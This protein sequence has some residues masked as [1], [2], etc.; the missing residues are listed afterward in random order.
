MY[1]VPPC[2]ALC[3]T[4]RSI[5]GRAGAANFAPGSDNDS[6]SAARVFIYFTGALNSDRFHDPASVH[7]VRNS[8]RRSLRDLPDLACVAVALGGASRCVL[9]RWNLVRRGLVRRSLRR[10]T[11][12]LGASS[13]LSLGLGLGMLLLKE[14]TFKTAQF[15]AVAEELCNQRTL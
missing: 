8:Q 3:A 6:R 2:R 10:R 11:A 9:G 15:R 14:P 13:C 1:H 7:N 4:G 12:P 5:G